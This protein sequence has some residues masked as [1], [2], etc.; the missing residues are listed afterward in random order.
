MYIYDRR[1]LR[2]RSLCKQQPIIPQPAQRNFFDPDLGMTGFGRAAS[3][4]INPF[5]RRIVMPLEMVNI[6][7]DT[8]GDC[9]KAASQPADVRGLCGAVV[10]LTG[11]PDLPPYGDITTPTCSMSAA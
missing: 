11:D 1:L 10:D 2:S 9:V 6:K 7:N 5:P 3:T 8:Y 4:V